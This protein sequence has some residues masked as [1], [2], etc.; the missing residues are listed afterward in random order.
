MSVDRKIVRQNRQKKRRKKNK[1][2][3]TIIDNLKSKI[4]NN[5]L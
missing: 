5:I 3:T 2:K 4:K 1:Q